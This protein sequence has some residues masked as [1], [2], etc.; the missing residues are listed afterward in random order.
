MEA[1]PASVE[2]R[3]SARI[4]QAGQAPPPPASPGKGRPPRAPESPLRRRPGLY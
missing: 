3:I 1:R 2:T 4:F